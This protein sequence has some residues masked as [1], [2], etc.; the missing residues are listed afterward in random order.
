[1]KVKRN[2]ISGVCDMTWDILGREIKVKVNKK[3]VKKLFKA[4]VGIKAWVLRELRSIQNP[5]SYTNLT[6][7]RFP[8]EK[9]AGIFE[10]LLEDFTMG[11]KAKYHVYWLTLRWLLL[12]TK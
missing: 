10:K 5:W 6:Y 12:H 7:K 9:T 11:K 1:M 8:D 2:R 3:V 4:N